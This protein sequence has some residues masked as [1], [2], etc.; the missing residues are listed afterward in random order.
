TRSGV[1]GSSVTTQPAAREMAFA[2]AP[3]A[4]MHGASP[5]PFAPFGPACSVGVSTH[6]IRISG[7]SAAGTSLYSW[8]S[9]LPRPPAAIS[10]RQLEGVER[11]PCVALGDAA[12]DLAGGAR[13]G[14]DR[15]AGVR[16]GDREHAD[17]A[18][19]A[20]DADVSCLREQLRRQEGLVAE[21]A[22]AALDVGRGR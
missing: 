18:R 12:V 2:I 10:W 7:A 4:G 17:D 6:A 11:G 19:V 15:A 14:E 5:T 21:A 9:G 1:I 13:G 16:S 8:T 22:D 20:V 3:A